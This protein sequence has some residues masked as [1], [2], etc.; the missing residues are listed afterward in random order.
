[1]VMYKTKL[2]DFFTKNIDFY[3]RLFSSYITL[4]LPLFEWN[5]IANKHF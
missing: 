5:K 1:M 4:V 2:F 3:A